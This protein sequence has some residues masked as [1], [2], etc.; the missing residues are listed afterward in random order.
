[1]SNTTDTNQASEDEKLAKLFHD[2]Y[3]RLAPAFSYKTRKASAVPWADVPPNNK[4]LMIAVAH[5]INDH[6]RTE[7]LKLLAEVRERA[8][9]TCI[10]Y[11]RSGQVG[12]SFSEGCDCEKC[13]KYEKKVRDDLAQLTQNPKSEEAV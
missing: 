5:E 6:I 4:G 10:K 3:E 7:K 8:V 12:G 13:D 1:M 2:T 9:D 11:I